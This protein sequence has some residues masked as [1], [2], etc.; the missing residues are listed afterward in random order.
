MT[1]KG[2]SSG[3]PSQQDQGRPASSKHMEQMGGVGRQQ[4]QGRGTPD[5]NE[6]QQAGAKGQQ[7]AARQ[8]GDLE[9]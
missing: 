6:E 5:E 9:R 3:Q 2:G 4:E 7:A 8:H 1:G